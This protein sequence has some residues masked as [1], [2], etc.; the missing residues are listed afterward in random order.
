MAAAAM[1]VVV[2]G[3]TPRRAERDDGGKSGEE[4][5]EGGFDAREELHDRT[6]GLEEKCDIGCCHFRLPGA[7]GHVRASRGPWRQ[8]SAI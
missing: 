3:V 4:S 1:K 5:T 7:P 2:R 6:S 8:I